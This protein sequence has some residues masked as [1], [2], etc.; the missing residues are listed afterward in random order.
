LLEKDKPKQF[1]HMIN[2]KSSVQVLV[3][4]GRIKSFHFEKLLTTS[5][6]E[7][8]RVTQQIVMLLQ[9]GQWKSEELVR[10]TSEHDTVEQNLIT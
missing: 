3:R 8:T 1:I 9:S 4:Y 10:L 7:T 6:D 2:T 5:E